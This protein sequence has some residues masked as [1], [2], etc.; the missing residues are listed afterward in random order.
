M[1][2]L[3]PGH[4]DR[5]LAARAILALGFGTL[6]LAWPAIELG[7]HPAERWGF[8]TEGVVGCALGALAFLRP[9]IPQA[10][11]C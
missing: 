3:S 6:A 2:T 4:A 8:V 5:P 7:E 11:G 9:F 1:N 10:S